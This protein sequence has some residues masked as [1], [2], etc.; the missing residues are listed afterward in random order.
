M[1]TYKR[2]T[3][4]SLEG[5]CEVHLRERGS[6]FAQLT[7]RRQ[8]QICEVGDKKGRQGRV[9]EDLPDAL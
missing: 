5:S 6:A 7:I 1:L 3:K 2:Q 4:S 8:M 9:T